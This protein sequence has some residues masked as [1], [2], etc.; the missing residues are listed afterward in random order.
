MSIQL[1][2]NNVN[3]RSRNMELGAVLIAA[4]V[5]MFLI[6]TG[7]FAW[8]FVAIG[9]YIPLSIALKIWLTSWR[10]ARILE[11]YRYQCEPIFEVQRGANDQF[12]FERAEHHRKML[13]L[14]GNEIY[15]R[16]LITVEE[17][18]DRD[19]RFGYAESNEEQA[20][21][22]ADYMREFLNNWALALTKDNAQFVKKWLNNQSMGNVA[23]VE[24]IE[25]TPSVFDAETGDFWT[26]QFPLFTRLVRGKEGKLI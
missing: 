2:I 19:P 26:K 1:E 8:A 25:E 22:R 5:S 3:E 9:A 23:T 7:D 11:L 13:I 17:I 21:R 14:S 10:E 6:A 16:T 12:N 15:A 4:L 20:I 18:Y 24:I